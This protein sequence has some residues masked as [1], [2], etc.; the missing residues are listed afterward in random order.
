MAKTNKNNNLFSVNGAL[1]SSWCLLPRARARGGLPPPNRGR[2]TI[3]WMLFRAKI[4]LRWNYPS[5]SNRL[6]FHKIN[7]W[8]QA[9]TGDV[10][11]L[12]FGAGSRQE[13]STS[14]M[15]GRSRCS[16]F[17]SIA[18][19]TFCFLIFFCS[20]WNVR[21][22]QYHRSTSFSANPSAACLMNKIILT[23]GVA[24]AA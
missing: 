19:Q 22:Q 16:L 8:W 6:V 18:A 9:S 17:F 23:D 14:T 12:P 1:A 13:G 20:R 24:V 4:I 15:S 2:W 7:S 3:W 10:T 11:A 21:H 5:P